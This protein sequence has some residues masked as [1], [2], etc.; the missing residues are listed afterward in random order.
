MSDQKGPVITNPFV[1]P[2]DVDKLKMTDP[3]SLEVVYDAQF[4]IRLALQGKQ[5]LI[6]FCGGPWTVF[7]YLVEG[8]SSAAF[9]KAKKWLY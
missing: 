5:A 9:T 1:K 2:E 4:M 8:G 6:G 7:S 3:E